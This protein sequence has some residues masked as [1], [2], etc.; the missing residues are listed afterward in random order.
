MM[1]ALFLG[2]RR[3]QISP[4]PLDL[5]ARICHHAGHDAA[6]V[7]RQLVQVGHCGRVQQLVWN[8][9]FD[10][11]TP[12][13]FTIMVNI[14]RGLCTF[15]RVA[16]AA[17]STPFTATEVVAPWLIALNAYSTWKRI[18]GLKY[19]FG[20]GNVFWRATIIHFIYSNN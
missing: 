18:D 2:E 5:A 6:N 9:E 4:R 10:K 13:S 14:L 11:S 20:K 8:L 7:V 15:L 16:T 12:S 19:L 17:V 1:E 3:Y